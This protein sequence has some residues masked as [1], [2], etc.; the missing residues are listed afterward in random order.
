MLEK[1]EIISRLKKGLS[2]RKI[3]NEYGVHRTIIR[4]LHRLAM[5]KGWLDPDARLPSEK[6]LILAFR[7]NGKASSKYPFEQ[8]LDD[9]KSWHSEGLTAIVIQRMLKQKHSFVCEIS[10]L[11]R[12]IRKHFIKLPDPV[13]I[14]TTVPGEIMDVDFGF[15]GKLWDN[16]ENRNRKVWVFSARLRH[17]RKAYRELVWNQDATTFLECHI[18]AFEY[19]N[20]VASKVVLDNLKAGVIKSTIDND[21]LNKSYI[22]CAEHYGFM[23][24]PCIPRTP[25]HK[26]GVENDMHYVKQSF[27]PELRERL[28]STPYITLKEAQKQLEEW[29]STVACCRKLRG[30]DRSPEELFLE[31]KELLKQLPASRFDPA[32]WFQCI[33]KRDWTITI[34][35]SRYSVPYNLIEKTVQ[36]RATQCIVKIFFDYEEVATHSKAAKK[37][38]YVRNSLHAPPFKEEVLA[39]NRQGLLTQAENIGENVLTFC[40]KMLANIYTDKLRAVRCL[41]RLAQHYG[42]DRLD[43][44]C[45]RA[46][47]YQTILYKSV[48]EILEKELDKEPIVNEIKL[49]TDSIFKYARDPREY[50]STGTFSQTS[51]YTG[52]FK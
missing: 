29:D 15:L 8:Y 19:F 6:E 9:I 24:S 37:G 52:D 3:A 51:N 41:L 7:P 48:K 22:E 50:Q 23:I 47:F 21:M 28:K 49:A 46:M 10:T 12:Y 26:G 43:K 42:N 25:Q 1:R 38:E 5:K 27:L 2:I 16:S 39:C 44:A 4:S 17:S 34:D 32:R 20:G 14:R 35:G 18:H 13:M 36:V 33:V 45:L 30:I 11:R 40:T 31:E